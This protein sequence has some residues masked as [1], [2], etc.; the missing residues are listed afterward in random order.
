MAD[1]D[2]RQ[3]LQGRSVSHSWVSL[4]PAPP[5]SRLSLRA[6]EA[7]IAA[8]SKALG[9]AL[10]ERPKT[11]ASKGDTTALWLGPDEWLLIDRD[12][13]DLAAAAGRVTAFHSAVDVSH[14]NV[15]ILVS[16]AGAEATI[17]AGCPQDISLAAFPVA[18]CSRTVLG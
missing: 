14:R 11:S 5:A 12:G 8:L 1:A 3:A 18:A 13:S 16:G 4:T 6:P 2:R 17:S 10:P 7:S 15:G 9:L